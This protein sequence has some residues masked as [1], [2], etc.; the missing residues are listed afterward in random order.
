MKWVRLQII[1]NWMLPPK[2]GSNKTIVKRCCNNLAHN[3]FFKKYCWV[4]VLWWHEIL[5]LLHSPC[6]LAYKW[7][8]ISCYKNRVFATK[9]WHFCRDLWDPLQSM[10]LQKCQNL[11]LKTLIQNHL[12]HI[13][14]A[15]YLWMSWFPALQTFKTFYWPYVVNWDVRESDHGARATS[16]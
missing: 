11:R 16:L 7:I 13:I 12:K 15:E 2:V 1:A 10:L 8:L 4:L 3:I 14:K 6:G 5:F 9:S